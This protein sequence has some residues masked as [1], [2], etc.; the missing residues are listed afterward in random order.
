[1]ADKELTTAGVGTS[2]GHRQRP[3]QVLV[4]IDF[5]IDGVARATGTGAVGAS[6]LNHEI[7]NH[8]MKVE[9]VVKALL[10]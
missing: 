2:M 10:G 5:T 3:S 7:V 1:M 4:V 6:P 8:T 9:A